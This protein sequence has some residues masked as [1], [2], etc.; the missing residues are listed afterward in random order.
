MKRSFTL[1]LAAFLMLMTN[2]VWGQTRD[3]EVYS[4]CLFG[5]SYNSQAVANYTSTWTATNG[6]FSWTIENANNNNNGWSFIRFGRKNNASVGSITTASAYSDAITK[7]ELT[8]DAIT[9]AK[10]NSIKLYSSNNNF[11]WTEIDEFDKA[12]GTQTVSIASSAANLYYKIEFDCAS[13]SSN[14]LVTVSKVEYYYNA[15]GAP[16]VATPT[17]SPAAGTYN[18]AQNVTISCTTAGATIYYTTNGDTPTTSSLVYSTPIAIS[19]TTTVKAMAVKTGMD[20]SSVATATYTIQ[21]IPTITTIA[22]LWEFAA[23]A[24]SST[25]SQPNA[26][27]TF[28][29]WYVTGVK[30]SQV[31]VSDGQY[32]FVIYQSSHG[33]VAGDKLSGTVACKVLMYQNHYAE[34]MGVKASDLTVVSGQD[35]PVLST[36]IAALEVRNYGTAINLGTCS[37][38][39]SKFYD[40]AG[41]SIALYNNFNVNPN[42]INSLVAGKQYNVKGVSIIYWQSNNQ[43]QQIVPRSADDFEEV[44]GP[45]E[46]VATPTFTPVEGTYTEAQDVTISTTTEGATIYYTLDG[47]TPTTNSSVYSTAITISETTTVKAF[48][49]KADMIDSEVATAEYTINIVPPTPTETS[50]KLITN[51]NALISGDKYIIVG[52]KGETYKA[53]G[54]QGTNNRPAVT[55]TPSNDTITVTPASAA[56]EDAVYELTLGQEG[57][58]WTLYDAAN[59]GYLYAASSSA[60][61]LKVQAEN[62]ANGQ[63]TIEIA[64]SGVATI[65]A[66]GTN[67]RNWLRLNSSGSPFSCYASGQADVYLYKAGDVPTPPAPSYYNVSVAQGITNGT[68]TVNPTTALEGDTITVTATPALGYELATLTYTYGQTTNNIDQTTMK[69]LMPASDV[70]VNATF[71]EMDAVATPTFTPAAGLYISAQTVTL[72]CATEGATIY[73][74]T[75]GTEPTTSSSV[76]AEP[77][78]VSMTTTV[79]AFAA[80]EGMNNSAVATAEYTII[81]VMTIASAR[82]LAVNEYALVQ[83]IVTFI[84]GRNIY[85]QDATAGIDLFFNSNTVPT[86]LAIGDMVKAYGKVAV[87]NGLVELSSING[88]NENQ[89]LVLSSGNPLP[90]AVKTIAEIL[91]DAAGDNMLQSTR[92]QIVDAICGTINTANNTPITQGESTLN[93]YKMPA[94]EGLLENDI[95]TVIGVLGCYNAPQLRV[96]SADDVT[97][98]HPAGITVNP[99]ALSGFNYVY[100]E[101][102]STVKTFNISAISL[103]APTYIYASE[104]YEISSFPGESFYPESLITINTYTGVYNYTIKVRLKAGLEIG[105][106]NEYITICEEELDTMY[107]ALSGNVTSTPPQP[108][109]DYT[110][111]SDLSQLT[112]GSKVIFAARFDEN[113]DQYYAMTAQTSGKP[114]GVLFTSATSASGETLPTTIADADSIYFWTVEIDGSNYIF[115]T[116]NGEVLGYT[117]GTNFATGGDNTAWAIT[118]QT[119]EE[120]AMVPNYGGFVVTNVN[121]AVRAIALNSNHNFGPYHTQNMTANNYN[122]FLDMFATEGGGTLTCATPTFNPEGGTY[123]EAQTVAI[124][125]A[126]ADAT[127]YYTLDGTEPDE[128]SAV[129]SEPIAV[130]ESMT[131]KAIA[132]KEGY[133]NSNVATAEYTIILGAVTIFNQDWEGDMNGWTFVTVEGGNAWTVAQYSGN[134]YAYANGYNGGV[135]EQWCIS[136]AFSLN[137]YSN[138]SLSFRNAKNYS[139]PDME[140]Y[141]SNDYDGENPATATWTE[142]EYEMSTGSYTWAESGT[143]DLAD[144]TGENCYIG[145]KYTSTETEAAAWEVDDVTLMGFTSDPYLTVTPS[146]LSGFT[147]HIDEGP[148]AS[149]T[150][151]LTAGNISPAPGGTTGSIN[152]SVYSPFEISLD[153]EEYDDEIFFEDVTNLEATTIYVRLNGTEI[154]Q[155]NETV[156]IY[157]SSGNE[158]TVTLSGTVTEQPVPGDDWNR[159]YSLSGLANGDQVILAAR[160]DATIGNGYYAMP[161]VV[162]GKPDGV[163]FTSVNNGGVETLPAEIA[164]D[165]ETYL[166]NVTLDGD[167]IILVNAEGDSLGY[168]S[169]TNFAGNVNTEW[170]IALETSEEGAMIPNYTGFVITNGTTTNR[171]IAKNASHKFGAYSTQNLANSDYNFY[172]DLFVQGGS[173]TPTVATPVFSMASGTYYEAI[174]VEITCSTEGA[175]IYYTL[176]GSAPTAASTVYTETIIVDEDM[177]IK[178]IAMM[179]GYDNSAIATASYVIMSDVVIILEQDW[180]GEMNGWEFVTVEG[181]KPWS[182]A[183]YNNNHY[184]Y[185]NGYNDDT[186]NEQWCISPAFNLNQYAEQNVTLTFMNAKNYSGP[187][188]E[189]YFTNDYDGQDPTAAEWIPLTYEMSTGGYSWTESG[190]ISLNGFSGMMCNIGFRYISTLND[191]AAAWE[192]DDIMIIANM[193]TDPYLTATP[194]VVG[195]L[196]HVIGYGPSEAQTFVVNGGNLPEGFLTLTL[197]NSDFEISLDGELYT[198]ASI[199]VPVSEPTLEPTTVYVRLNGEEVGNYE[200]TIIIDVNDDVTTTVTVSGTVSDDSIGESLAYSVSVWNNLNELMIENN[201]NAP[202]N[203][204]VY[205]ILGQPVLSATIATGSNVIRHNLAEGVYIVRIANGKEMKGVKIVVSR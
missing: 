18:E 131:I 149:Q 169:S 147:H 9:A 146:A 158:A 43:T 87:Y 192:V 195:G 68:V 188:L 21:Q 136:P 85:V 189:L 54:K 197:D 186:D 34:V 132:M 94:V 116:N 56:G 204:E 102:P 124:A 101:G 88:G 13:G 139:G 11:S 193:G 23:T 161:A 72:E 178:A 171:G 58:Y 172:L 8:I 159:I 82:A 120:G 89:F 17:F 45:T 168:S 174:E 100:E 77:F 176:D 175:T 14:G 57:N 151:V 90:L 74:T 86:T 49:V 46:Q 75:D 170:N 31:C 36:T 198:S 40:A 155:Y 99:T 103:G 184:A 199:T 182:V 180:E 109:G 55:V 27:V 15:S 7:V 38:N 73:Y 3:E 24:G 50:Y 118:Y 115:T 128:N 12:T 190:L 156:N 67:T 4:T 121:N 105:E 70:T 76:Y 163:L 83:G 141:F 138:A 129:F 35:V 26:N 181:N 183:T 110:R 25:P 154:G 152:V 117:S 19:T 164:D 97:F 126:T 62:D 51:A 173:V 32:G 185:A 160:Y 37:Y 145:F 205:N 30:S 123:Y 53:L 108:Q 133:E 48:A 122:F 96:N 41:D 84:D 44:V 69:F 162:S 61:H 16:T 63:W 10:I 166:W 93:L 142:L 194:N 165:S 81:E 66:Q 64:S 2:F 150:F 200:D 148:S 104:N 71:T 135:N 125:C 144:F 52:I 177:T 107:I 130:A 111:V 1:M 78:T 28:N 191:G 203:V 119:S 153:D 112:S 98:T 80:K 42:P 143:I 106:Y 95:V 113:A 20:N 65:K 201:F 196:T 140:V 22:G 179:E 202:L 92:V 167:V 59:E 6:S 137:V 5:S 60:N 157:A 134:H 33:F 29:D 187:D 91:E 47:T 79:K 127:I 114:T 39:G